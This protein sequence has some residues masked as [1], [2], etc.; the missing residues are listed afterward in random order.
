MSTTSAEE[1]LILR[2]VKESPNAY[3]PLR[4]IAEGLY[5]VLDDCEV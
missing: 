2:G 4:S 1:K 3:P 5:V